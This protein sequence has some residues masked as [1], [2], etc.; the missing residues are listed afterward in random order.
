MTGRGGC[1]SRD[2]SLPVVGDWCLSLKDNFFD[3][4]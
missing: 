2:L 3:G 4:K 1:E